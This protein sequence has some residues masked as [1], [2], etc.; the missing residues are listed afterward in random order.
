M[1]KELRL[2]NFRLFDNDVA[3]RLRPI[4]SIDRAK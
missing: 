3:I 1:L 2:S 4:T